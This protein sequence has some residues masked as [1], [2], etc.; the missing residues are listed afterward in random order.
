MAQSLGLGQPTTSGGQPILGAPVGDPAGGGTPTTGPVQNNSLVQNLG[1]GTTII[2]GQVS[3][4][5][6]PQG[7][8]PSNPITWGQNVGGTFYDTSGA[9]QGAF[10]LDQINAMGYGRTADA[11]GYHSIANTA[12]AYAQ[13]AAAQ[14]QQQQQG[15]AAFGIARSSGGSGGSSAAMAPYNAALSTLGQLQ[16][17]LASGKNSSGQPLGYYERQEI[18]AKI[19]DTYK[20]TMN[21]STGDEQQLAKVMDDKAKLEAQAYLNNPKTYNG[22]VNDNEY[23]KMTL[24]AKYGLNAQQVVADGGHVGWG[25]GDQQYALLQDAQ[26]LG[27]A[28]PTSLLAKAAFEGAHWD[29]SQQI[30]QPAAGSPGD[31]MSW[32]AGLAYNSMGVGAGQGYTNNGAVYGADPVWDPYAW[33][34]WYEPGGGYDQTQGGAQGMWDKFHNSNLSYGGGTYIGDPNYGKIA[35]QFDF[36][37]P[38]NGGPSVGSQ[39][40]PTYDPQ[41]ALPGMIQYWKGQGYS[42]SQI[43]QLI[44]ANGGTLPPVASVPTWTDTMAEQKAATDYYRKLVGNGYTPELGTMAEFKRYMDKFLS[45]SNSH[46]TGSYSGGSGDNALNRVE[47]HINDLVLGGPVGAPG[48]LTTSNPTN[49]VFSDTT[50]RQ[51]QRIDNSGMLDGMLQ[52]QLLGAPLTQPYGGWAYPVQPMPAAPAPANAGLLNSILAQYYGIAK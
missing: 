47:S 18:Q 9:I 45:D 13:Q 49:D 29:Q 52:G 22:V 8:S 5:A 40:N 2:N 28:V 42:P 17:Q 23:Q 44:E 48:T 35:T 14:Q 39:A 25:A 21:W 12:Q 46:F 38:T 31:A 26:A 33:G 34:N 3:Q 4:Q 41:G 19:S 16:N 27:V 7:S 1:N 6:A 10:T 37:G 11:T 43:D 51:P 30:Y 20:Q 50:L 32:N 24:Q 15:Q 36:Q